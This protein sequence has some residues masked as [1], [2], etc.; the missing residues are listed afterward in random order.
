MKVLSD[1]AKP[2]SSNIGILAETSHAD[3]TIDDDQDDDIEVVSDSDQ[4]G[5]IHTNGVMIYSV[6]RCFISLPKP[7]P[8]SPNPRF[9]DNSYSSP[10]LRQRATPWAL[11]LSALTHLQP[12][13]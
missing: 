3:T 12:L 13:F 10:L 6:R 1:I 9:H 7:P 4:N 5:K 8:P 11:V 2:S